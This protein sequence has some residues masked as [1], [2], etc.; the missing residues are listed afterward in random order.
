MSSTTPPRVLAVARPALAMVRVARRAVDIGRVEWVAVLAVGLHRLR[1]PLR[2]FAVSLA[3]RVRDR[4]D[5]LGRLDAMRPAL[6]DHVGHVV[7]G[8]AQPQMLGSDAWRVI[9]TVQDEHAIGDGAVG[10]QPRPTM[11]P[12]FP[13][14]VIAPLDDPVRLSVTVARPDPAIVTTFDLRPEARILSTFHVTSIP[15]GWRETHE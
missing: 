5:V 9:A 2:V 11:S 15:F 3:L 12:R 1:V 13:S 10:Q 14:P 7:V 8:R 4:L 6:R